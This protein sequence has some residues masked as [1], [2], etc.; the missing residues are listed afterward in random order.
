MYNGGPNQST[1]GFANTNG[2]APVPMPAGTLG[3]GAYRPQQNE[4]SE[5]VLILDTLTAG[6]ST[7]NGRLVDVISLVRCHADSIFGPQ[8]ES[9]GAGANSPPRD[10]SRLAGLSDA[11]RGTDELVSEL[12]QQI[13]RLTAL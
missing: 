12:R 11:I 8:P 9:K 7:S 13:N 4:E 6:L 3:G 5:R 2:W 10:P 1:G